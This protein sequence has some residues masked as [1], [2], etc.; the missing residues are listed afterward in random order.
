M[1]MVMTPEA[2]TDIDLP[3]LLRTG[4]EEKVIMKVMMIGFPDSE[5]VSSFLA[6]S[7][8]AGSRSV[9]RQWGW[10]TLIALHV[11]HPVPP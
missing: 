2:D 4:Q 1:D 11:L 3:L 8:P 9:M 5:K 10:V 6:Q 7:K